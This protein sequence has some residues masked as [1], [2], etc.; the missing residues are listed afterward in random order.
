MC[1]ITGDPLQGPTANRPGGPTPG[2]DAPGPAARARLDRGCAV[3][4]SRGGLPDARPPQP[5][6]E[7]Q[8]DRARAAVEALATVRELSPT[9]GGVR[10][11]VAYE[12]EL[13]AFADRVE[14]AEETLD[15]LS[16]G[17]RCRSSRRS[18]RRGTSTAPMT[19]PRSPA[20]LSVTRMATESRVDTLHSHPFWAR[21]FADIAL[22]HNGH[23]NQRAQAAP[24]PRRQR[25]PS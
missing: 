22:V 2:R 21:P 14:A 25:P 8:L 24:P 12:G 10:A 18:A 11:S 7:S 15:V 23:T 1:G 4:T 9:P 19:S 16:L 3:R 13:A 20:A 5:D 17:T 6:G